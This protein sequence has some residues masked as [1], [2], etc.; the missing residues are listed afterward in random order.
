MRSSRATMRRF[1]TPPDI[2]KMEKEVIRLKELLQKAESELDAAHA[3]FKAKKDLYWAKE[4]AK[5]ELGRSHHQRGD[6][7]FVSQNRNAPY[8][9]KTRIGGATEEKGGVKPQREEKTSDLGPTPLLD[10]ELEEVEAANGDV[11]GT[12][13]ERGIHLSLIHI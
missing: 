5:Q 11:T 10:I 12:R 6:R 9:T 2:R 3:W 13:G 7:R 1:Q 4:R 8:P